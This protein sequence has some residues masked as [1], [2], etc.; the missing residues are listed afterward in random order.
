MPWWFWIISHMWVM[1]GSGLF[2]GMISDNS[3]DNESKLGVV[4]LLIVCLFGPIP[5]I[6]GVV[7]STLQEIRFWD[8]LKDRWLLRKIIQVFKCIKDYKERR[9]DFKEIED[10][11]DE[12]TAERVGIKLK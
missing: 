8:K 4:I 2:V 12:W 5:I 1:C 3:F 6:I 10:N 11:E 7:G 9:N